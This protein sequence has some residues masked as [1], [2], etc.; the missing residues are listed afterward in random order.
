MQPRVCRRSL[1]RH[2]PLRERALERSA[3]VGAEEAQRPEVQEDVP[4]IV[5][6]YQ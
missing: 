6:H 5:Y 1:P 2:D 3:Q 4:Y